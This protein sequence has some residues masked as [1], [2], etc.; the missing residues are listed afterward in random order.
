MV[1]AFVAICALLM[2]CILVLVGGGLLVAWRQRSQAR[3]LAA[4]AGWRYEGMGKF[5]GGA[6]A[7]EWRGGHSSDSDSGAAWTLFETAIIGMP[8][9]GFEIVSCTAH[10]AQLQRREH[11]ENRPGWINALG[12]A[13]QALSAALGPAGRLLLG[14][15]PTQPARH[16]ID[17]R[18]TWLPQPVGAAAF[19]AQWVLLAPERY[20][21]AVCTPAV[22]ALWQQAATLHAGEL[23][24]QAQSQRLELRR[25]DERAEPSLEQVAALLRLGMALADAV[26]HCVAA[27]EERRPPTAP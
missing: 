4:K 9:G 14:D 5:S 12:R 6:G 17:D 27:R 16:T 18:S 13:D 15:L 8:P 23:R 26:K 1:L 3:A 7:L 19:D 24:V 22:L 20:W 21:T 25:D 10:Q 2:L 11:T